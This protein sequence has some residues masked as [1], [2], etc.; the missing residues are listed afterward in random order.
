[1]CHMMYYPPGVPADLDDL[2]R[3]A[4]VNDEGH[5]MA[6]LDDHG[7]LFCFKSMSADV[8]ISTFDVVRRAWPDSPAVFH[9]R[10]ATTG[11]VSF[12]EAH[13]VLTPDR[14]TAV[15]LNGTLD[16]PLAPGESDTRRFASEYLS[17]LNPDDHVHRQAIED[18]A[19]RCGAKLLLLTDAKDRLE[20]VYVINQPQWIVTPYGALASNADHLGKGKGWAERTDADGTLWRWRVRQPGQCTGCDLYGCTTHHIYPAAVPPAYRNETERRQRVREVA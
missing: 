17:K 13:P 19:A 16:I 2:A 6:W 9:S 11:L 15:F 20:P 8:A 3:A 4:E 14:H 1:M 12:D 5:G 18:V 10:L 7:L